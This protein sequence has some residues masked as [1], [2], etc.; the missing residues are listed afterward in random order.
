MKVPATDPLARSLRVLDT[1][2]RDITGDC[3]CVDLRTGEALLYLRDPTTRGFYVVDG[4]V[5]SDTR[6]GCRV[7]VRADAPDWAR[8]ATEAFVGVVVE[9]EAA[10]AS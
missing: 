10:P 7:V 3:F 6:K 1:E 9:H 2:G 5:A 4:E 8:R